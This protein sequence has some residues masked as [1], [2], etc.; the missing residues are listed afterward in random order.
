MIFPNVK[1]ADLNAYLQ[2]FMDELTAKV[3]RTYNASITLEKELDKFDAALKQNG[4]FMSDVEL[5]QFYND[6]NRQVAVL[7][8][9]QRAVAK[10]HEASMEKMNEKVNAV[11][12]QL[13]E[14]SAELKLA[15]KK[16]ED[17]TK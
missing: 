10:T 6:A 11:K 1:P 12:E 14:A 13:R 8:N 16:G 17:V 7:C 4:G 9:H 5:V 3:F 2:M 15:V